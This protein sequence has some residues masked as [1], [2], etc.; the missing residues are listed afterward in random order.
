MNDE[1]STIETLRNRLAQ[2]DAELADILER[3][4]AHG[5]KPGFMAALLNLEDERDRLRG[6][7]QACLSR[8]P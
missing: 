6:D 5:V 2:V 7:I 1:P 4:P 3:M 8:L